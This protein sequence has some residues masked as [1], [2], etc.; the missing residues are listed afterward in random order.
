MN[1]PKWIIALYAAAALVGCT[2][3][4]SA[5]APAGRA[6]PAPA[7]STS[8]PSE[9]AAGAALKWLIEVVEAGGN[10]APGEI[11]QRF[12][13]AFLEALPADQLAALFRDFGAT[14]PPIRV[15]TSVA[16]SA[17]ERHA[18]LDTAEG[19]TRV[20][21]ALDDSEPPRIEGLLFRPV[22]EP[23]ASIHAAAATITGAGAQSGL[24]IAELAHGRCKP[25]RQIGETRSFA[26]G[27]TF[28]LWVL[29]A[30]G[31]KLRAGNVKWD[32]LL[33]VRDAQKSLPSGRLQDA[34]D[35]TQ[36]S[37]R[38]AA[39]GMIA[40]SDNTATDLLIGLL[41]REHVEQVQ[42]IARH[43]DPAVNVPWLTTRELFMLKRAS[44]EELR[45]A[46]LRA[47]VPEKR[48]L[49]D[50]LAGQP[51]GDVGRELLDTW[52]TPRALAL[53]WFGS[54]MDVCNVL[55]TLGARGG[56]D[57]RSELLRILSLNP[58]VEST[59]GWKYIGYKGG[60]EPGVLTVSWLLQREDGRWFV[61]VAAVND[62]TKLLDEDAI[63]NAAS[64]VVSLLS[65]EQ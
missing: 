35:G 30:L 21:L 8:T 56:F 17:R 50:A 13:P 36:V 65:E 23:P 47:T 42:T 4:Q 11:E 61:V 49:L 48:A 55:A 34:P 18:V 7:A 22:L 20:V 26:L 41:G 10:F 29:L 24:L 32:D 58:G 16:V 40:I 19:P 1:L 46:Y 53:E 52:N 62:A 60:S 9:D 59:R 27:S 44:A 33:T 37:V 51:F 38:D 15:V 25:I 5:D 3:S 14:L 64:G 39:S 2:G 54:T 12:A 45:A 6:V 63:V 57:P 43:Q 28:K 31:E